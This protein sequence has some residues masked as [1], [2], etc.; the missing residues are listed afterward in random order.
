MA[1]KT[2]SVTRETSTG[3]NTG[4]IDKQ[5]GSTMTRG[6]FVKQIEHG[7]YPAY[8]VRVINGVKTPASNPDKKSSNNLG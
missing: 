4:F 5:T 7:N 6:Q 1:K 2:V 8:H 3:R